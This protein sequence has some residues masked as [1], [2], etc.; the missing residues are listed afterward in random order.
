M[1]EIDFLGQVIR[2]SEF[3]RVFYVL[4]LADSI[5]YNRHVIFSQA[6][7]FLMEFVQYKRDLSL[8][9]CIFSTNFQ[10]YESG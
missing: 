8:V 5:Q 7:E 10:E 3:L 4:V 2:G 9:R 1:L 6:Q